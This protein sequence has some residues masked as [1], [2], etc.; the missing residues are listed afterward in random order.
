[1]FDVAYYKVASD[2]GHFPAM[3]K[4]AF[5]IEEMRAFFRAYRR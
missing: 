3:E 2:G 4:G 5:L 1:V